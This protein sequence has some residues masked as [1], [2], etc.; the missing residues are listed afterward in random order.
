[1]VRKKTTKTEKNIKPNNNGCLK[2][3]NEKIT[4]SFGL[5]LNCCMLL[6]TFIRDINNLKITDGKRLLF[7]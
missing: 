4:W 7:F 3:C 1:V 2:I 5:K 6:D